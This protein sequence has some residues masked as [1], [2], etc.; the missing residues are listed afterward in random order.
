MKYGRG[1]A[2]KS[3]DWVFGGVERD[4]AN[5]FL[6]VVARRNAATLIPLIQKWILPGTIIY[7]DAWKAY[8]SLRYVNYVLLRN[9]NKL[10]FFSQ[11]AWLR[12]SRRQPQQKLQGPENRSAH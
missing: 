8:S 6:E 10:V 11:Q 5:G 7:S 9:N 4:G 1:E 12:P 3:D 2:Q